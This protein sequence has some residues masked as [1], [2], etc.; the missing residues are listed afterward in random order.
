MTLTTIEYG[1]IASSQVMNNNFSYLNNRITSVTNTINTSISTLTSNIATI[2]TSISELAEDLEDFITDMEANFNDFKQKTQIAIN[3][4]NMSPNWTN[5]SEIQSINNYTAATNGYLL[6]LPALN[7]DGDITVN[8]NGIDFK[9]YS[10]TADSAS[11]LVV[12]PVSKNDVITCSCTF[13][14]AYFLPA[15]TVVVDAN[16]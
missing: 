6:I 14:K 2:N 9:T 5:V 8:T 1:S 3:A 10:V 13:L 11:E 4:V 12:I 16:D 15:K 7:G